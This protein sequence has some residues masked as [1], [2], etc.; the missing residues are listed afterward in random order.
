MAD[1]MAGSFAQRGFLTGRFRTGRLY[2]L[3][4]RAMLS[5]QEKQ[6]LGSLADSDEVYGLFVPDVPLPHLTAKIAFLD[7]ALLFFHFQQAERLPQ[8]FLTRPGA[9]LQKL[10]AHLVLDQILE[11]AWQKDFVSGSQAV[12]AVYNAQQFPGEAP[13]NYLSGLSLQAI[14]YAFLL[15][16]KDVQSLAHWLYTCHTLPPDALADRSL[17]SE[18]DMY[19]YL[20]PQQSHDPAVLL[21]Q[22]QFVPPQERFRWFSW[23]RPH[24]FHPAEQP[25][26]KLYLSPQPHRL[27]ALLARLLPV[28]SGSA[29]FC[30]KAGASAAGILRPDKLVVYFSSAEGMRQMVPHL[31]PLL[32]G[33]PVHGV[34]FTAQLD[35]DGLLSWGA[36]PP[37]GHEPADADGG[38]WRT[39]VAGQLALAVLAA[40]AQGKQLA[41]A[42]PF[43]AAKMDAA[44]INFRTWAP[45]GHAG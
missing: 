5:R 36:D 33:E 14:S 21:R 32:Q 31:L 6:W 34:P 12:P 27:S 42:L 13:A 25:T 40:R 8:S 43:V 39:T 15:N 22:W 35:G 18:K 9:E 7:S 29:A 10:M 24:T 23:T 16:R 1:V 4:E 3:K 20:F 2:R 30:V 38:S 44:G 28:V 41:E 17:A 45:A 37:A 11:V 19:H 26:F